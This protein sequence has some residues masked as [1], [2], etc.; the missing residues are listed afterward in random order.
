MEETTSEMHVV[1]PRMNGVYIDEKRLHS[2]S[3]LLV[4]KYIILRVS[5]VVELFPIPFCYRVCGYGMGGRASQR[6][7]KS[8][9]QRSKH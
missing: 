4:D 2:H 6:T 5:A 1:P 9:K 8:V 7:C 3:H